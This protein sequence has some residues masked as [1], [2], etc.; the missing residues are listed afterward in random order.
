M[1]II[2]AP[3]IFRYVW[4]IVKNFFDPWAVAKMTFTGPEDAE[5]KLSRFMDLKVLPPCIS[6]KHGKGKA[7]EGMPQRWEGG[8]PPSMDYT[9]PISKLT[10]QTIPVQS[11]SL[12]QGS[13]SSPPAAAKMEAERRVTI[14]ASSLGS[15]FFDTNEKGEILSPEIFH[16]IHDTDMMVNPVA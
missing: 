16:A 8:I 3:S 6:P 15:G 1:I 11:H 12:P 10:F 13:S 2:R 9:E 14:N 5:E 7:A 4:A